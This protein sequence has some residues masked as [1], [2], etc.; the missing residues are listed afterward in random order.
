MFHGKL[1]INTGMISGKLYTDRYVSWKAV[2]KTGMIAG[3]LYTNT[4][5]IAGKLYRDRLFWTLSFSGN[6]YTN[7]VL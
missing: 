3:K 2:F 4:G 1:Y 7:T 5:M 6:L